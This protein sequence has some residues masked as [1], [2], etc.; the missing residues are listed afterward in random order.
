MVRPEE[1]RRVV[2]LLD[3]CQSRTVVATNRA[4]KSV[5][6]SCRHLIPQDRTATRT[7]R[8]RRAKVKI[9]PESRGDLSLTNV[10]CEAGRRLC[11]ASVPPKTT[12]LC[13]SNRWTHLPSSPSESRP[14]WQRSAATALPGKLKRDMCCGFPGCKKPLE[15]PA[16]PV[17]VRGAPQAA[18][19]GAGCGR[20]RNSGGGPGRVRRSCSPRQ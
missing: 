9:R 7:R 4:P 1:V 20:R 6:N 11:R 15:E 3:P 12:R 16:V 5:R 8:V 14:R 2:L 18:K 10:R 19:E 13:P 17:L